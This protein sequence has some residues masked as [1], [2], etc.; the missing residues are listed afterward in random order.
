MFAHW[1]TAQAQ[2]VAAHLLGVPTAFPRPEHNSAV[3][4]TSPEIGMVGLTEEAARTAGIDAAVAEYDYRGDART[5]ISGDAF[6]RLRIV[7]RVDDRRVIGVHALVEGAGDLMGEAAL[8]VRHGLTLDQVATAIHPHP[9]L[10]EAFGLA[11]LHA[12]SGNG[13]PATTELRR[14]AMVQA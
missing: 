13:V 11:A 6:G 14:E 3:I 12:G 1:A 2:A 5:Q 4:F 9:T 7:H 8:V 10:T